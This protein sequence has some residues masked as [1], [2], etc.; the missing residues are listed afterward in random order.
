MS[1]VTTNTNFIGFSPPQE[2]KDGVSKA[3]KALDK[4][5]PPGSQRKLLIANMGI[6]YSG[7]LKIK[8]KAKS[9]TVYGSAPSAKELVPD[10]VESA[11]Q[12]L[13]RWLTQGE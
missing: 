5:S 7:L 13:M 6:S 2:F 8:S 12:R 3:L 10:L 1:E 9:F 11:Q 4:Y